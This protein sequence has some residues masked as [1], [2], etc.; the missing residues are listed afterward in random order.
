[1]ADVPA[2]DDEYVEIT[3]TPSEESDTTEAPS[4]EPTDTEQPA[5]EAPTPA[6][7]SFDEVVEY[8]R[9][10]EQ[11]AAEQHKL[12][13]QL[14]LRADRPRSS[15]SKFNSATA[16]DVILSDPEHKLALV[17][18]KVRDK[19]EKPE[20]LLTRDLQLSFVDKRTCHA[21]IMKLRGCEMARNMG[22]ADLAKRSY[23]QIL[24]YLSVN[25][26]IHG[27]ERILQTVLATANL[28]VISQAAGQ[29]KNMDKSGIDWVGALKGLNK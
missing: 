2:P 1:M 4:A 7:P 17:R 12:I 29:Q 16:D 23:V 11:Q 9:A 28:D 26:S 22:H 3:D 21:L 19:I 14:Q 27:F 18:A 13:E 20:D 5:E 10:L 24:Q 25:K 8:A 6:P 15:Y